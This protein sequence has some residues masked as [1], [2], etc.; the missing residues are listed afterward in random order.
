MKKIS[1]RQTLALLV[2]AASVSASCGGGSA[3]TSGSSTTTSANTTTASA[4]TGTPFTSETGRFKVTLP[5]G[6]A[7]F[8]E[9]RN[10]ATKMAGYT[11]SGPNNIACNVSYS[12]FSDALAGEL[13]APEKLEKALGVMR[14]NSVKG[15]NGIAERE[16]NISV[17]GH[18]GLSVYGT[19]P[20]SQTLYFRMDNVI[21]N[22][23]GYRFGCLS[24][25]KEDLDKP[26]IR[27]FFESFQLN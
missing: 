25:N 2:V 10:E 16:E 23:R 22:S 1:P 13:N 24:M 19:I 3:T 26:E 14:D 11:S 27:S 17:Q 20:G 18:P 4:S 8:Q 15:M 6:F 7:P 5:S 9:R 21:A 12:E